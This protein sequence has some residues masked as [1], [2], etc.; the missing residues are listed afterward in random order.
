MPYIGPWGTYIHIPKTGGSFVKRVLTQIQAKTNSG[1][2][3]VHD[4][5]V[6]WRDGDIWTSV[7]D[8][9]E[10]L[11]SVWAWNNQTS[12]KK[13]PYQVPWHYFCSIL[14]DY[15][16]G[17]FK[18]WIQKITTKLPGIVGWL[19]GMYTPPTVVTYKLGPELYQKL[20]DIGGYPDAIGK[21][22]NVGHNTP[23]ITPG[24]RQMVYNAERACYDRYNFRETT[25]EIP[26]EKSN[27]NENKNLS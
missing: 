13:Y 27:E 20:R 9:A 1:G 17:H 22:I 25:L 16:G 18:Q 7:R 8:P 10:W 12:W 3:R 4:L 5:P 2:A 15:K 26:K 19:Y 6:Y 24:I 21:D 23:E 11:G 14:N